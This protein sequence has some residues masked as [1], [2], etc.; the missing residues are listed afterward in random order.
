MAS[1]SSS[2]YTAAVIPS[3]GARVEYREFP[4]PAPVKGGLLLRVQYAGVCG[5]DRYLW[6]GKAAFPVPY[7]LGHE[8]IGRIE[9][10]G[11]G[12]T[13]DHAGQPVTVGDSVFWNPVGPCNACYHCTIE[14]DYTSCTN[15]S[16][17]SPAGEG[18]WASYTTVANLKPENAFFRIDPST[19]VEAVIAVGCA[20]TTI[21]QGVDNL[22]PRGIEPDSTVVIQ[23]AGPLG[24]ASIM[25]ASLARAKHIL[26][27]EM[28]DKRLEIARRFGATEVIDM[29][30]YDS[31]E[32]RA[33]RIESILAPAGAGV[34]LVI[35]CS[36]SSH[37]FAEGLKLLRR[38]SRY[39][40]VGTWAGDAD[41][42]VNPYHIVRNAQQIIGTTYAGPKQYYRAVKLVERYHREF[43]LA[44]C[45]T[46]K[47]PLV[48]CEEAFELITNGDTVK[49]LV[50]PSQQ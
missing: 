24:L 27:L 33:Q 4:T 42:P 7:V 41:V 50:E 37:A 35:E 13:K 32:R 38:N 23:G 47:L 30:E 28:H 9:A 16:F 3:A 11:E 2:N 39:L 40:L 22:G 31:A 8:G 46:H 14:G 21:L 29:R 48:R 17:L 1:K 34:D 20:L 15:S 44:D 45:V 12:V 26:V 18:P 10:L 49:V 6:Q 36:G 43:P 5:T 19:P 25:V